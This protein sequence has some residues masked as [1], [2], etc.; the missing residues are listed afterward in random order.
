MRHRVTIG[1][2]GVAE[3]EWEHR[4]DAPDEVF[5]REW[6]LSGKLCHDVGKQEGEVA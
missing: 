5:R 1:L 4:R 6:L 3:T 2:C